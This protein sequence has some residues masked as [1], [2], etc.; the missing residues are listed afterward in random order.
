MLAARGP[1]GLCSTSYCTLSFSFSVLNPLAWM[2]EKCTK[3]SLL[4]SSGVMKPKPLASLNHFT[5]PVLMSDASIS[6]GKKGAIGREAALRKIKE[7]LE[8]PTVSLYRHS[9]AQSNLA[10]PRQGHALA[11][12]AHRANALVDE[13]LQALALVGLGRVEVALRVGGD[14]VHA[15]ELAGLA[16]AVAETGQLLQ[17]LA[18]DDAHLLVAA[19]GHEN[20]ALLRIAR[21]GDV[22]DRAFAQAAPRIPLLLDELA[23]LREHLQAI[24]LPVAD[25]HQAVVRDVGAVHRVAELLRR[26]RVGI[27]RPE[28]AVVGLVAVGAPVALHL[29]GVGVEHGDALVLVAV[30]DERLVGLRVDEDLRHAAKVLQVV[31][32]LVVAVPAHLQQ[33]LAVLAELQHLRVLRAVAADPDIALVV[34]EDAMVRLG[35]LVARSR[36]APVPHPVAGLVEHQH[37]RRAAAAFAGRRA[38]LQ[39]LLVVVERGRAAMDD[40]DVVL[41]VDPD[42]D[43]NADQPVVGQWLG[44]Q[45]IAFEHRRLRHLRLVGLPVEERLRAA[46]RREQRDE[47]RADCSAIR[48]PC[49]L[50]EATG[51]SICKLCNTGCDW[52]AISSSPRHFSRSRRARRRTT[53]PT[54]CASRPSSSPK[55]RR[56]NCWCACRSRRCATS[57]CR[58]AREVSSTSRASTARCA[59]RSPCGSPARSSFTRTTRGSASRS[60]SMPASRSS[61]TAP[62]PRT[63]ARSRISRS[64]AS[65]TTPSSTGT[66]GCWT[67]CSRTRCAPSALPSRS[68]RGSSGSASRSTSSC[69]SCRRAARRGRSTCTATPASCASIRAGTRRR[70]ASCTR[71]FSISCR[72]PTT[73]S[74]CSAS[75]SRSGASCRS[76]LSSPPSPS[77]T[78]SPSS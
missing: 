9:S 48:H 49:L 52:I 3:R 29:A 15:E 35:P 5:V 33:E 16:A 54:K 34:D 30:G 4:P 58:S 76:P 38:E 60:R 18:Q 8:N 17:R 11:A 23:V 59:T 65:A 20:V 77:R 13:L 64:R 74:S 71:A 47:R 53:S 14:A 67:C 57:T 40:P 10:L 19:V 6:I 26:R 51:P 24:V 42:T 25:V 46:E 78:P 1:L 36:A 27:V 56:L 66:R 68:G 50:R 41:L 2:D 63:K 31:A 22:P 55:A 43:R 75:S 62:S 44:P 28:V 32:A 69:A 12:A 70:C 37:R 7:L 21:E 39:A 61:R 73:F 72:A 45:R